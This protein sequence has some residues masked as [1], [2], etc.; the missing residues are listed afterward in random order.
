[1]ATATAAQRI[2]N[3]FRFTPAK[4]VGATEVST[5][6]FRVCEKKALRPKGFNAF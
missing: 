6:D 4:E 2:P 3:K 5:Q 1:M